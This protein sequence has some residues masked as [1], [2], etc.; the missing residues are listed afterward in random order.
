MDVSVMSWVKHLMPVSRVMPAKARTAGPG[1]RLGDET[2]ISPARCC[3][4]PAVRASTA[5]LLLGLICSLP[6]LAMAQADLDEQVK[7]RI[8]ELCKTGKYSEAAPLEDEYLRTALKTGR[9]AGSLFTL[10]NILAQSGADAV[11]AG[12]LAEAES[13]FRCALSVDQKI[14][15]PTH[16]RVA[17]D[18]NNLAAVLKDL[19][20]FDEAESHVRSALTIDKTY[21][22]PHS[23]KVANDYN[24]LGLLLQTTG[25]YAE[26]EKLY[27][28]GLDILDKWP[29]DHSLLKND[30][31]LLFL[32]NNLATLL[33]DKGRFAEAEPLARRAVAL[34]KKPGTYPLDLAKALD[35]WGYLLGQTNHLEEAVKQYSEAL[36]IATNYGP[37]SPFASTVLIDWAELLARRGDWA[38][39]VALHRR[40]SKIVLRGG[41]DVFDRA[42]VTKAV[43]A[44]YDRNFALYARA[45]SHALDTDHGDIDRFATTNEAFEMAQWALHTAAA[46]A[47][48]QMS[49]RFAKGDGPLA[50]LAREHQD[51]LAKRR[52]AV[53]QLD[54]ADRRGDALAK[55]HATAYL[56]NIDRQLDA[57]DLKLAENFPDYASLTQPKPLSI[58]ATSDRLRDDEALFLFLDVPD[59][60][61]PNFPPTRSGVLGFRQVHLDDVSLFGRVPFLRP[62]LLR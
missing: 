5:L 9:G 23:R 24:N 56:A 59:D 20:E 55:D 61:S 34:A 7:V 25:R 43:R 19:G 49:A 38:G 33:Q 17:S 46:E 15:G 42:G 28:D 2:W 44:K 11:A 31:P 58:Q 30:D 57:K 35:S 3:T 16:T 39:A 22:G 48:T 60:L 62:G 12:R 53:S 6:R 27:R 18:L 36:S 50:I 4:K 47:L 45:L 26:A 10:P 40:A 41:T 8:A 54:A 14:Y 21:P 52:I 1:L 32:I 37:D 51:L 13:D 29:D